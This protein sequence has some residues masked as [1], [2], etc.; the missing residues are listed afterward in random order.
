[1][2]KQIIYSL[3]IVLCIAVFF[4]YRSAGQ[5]RADTTAPVITV[6][7]EL[8]QPSVQD[9]NAALLA[10]VSAVDDRDGDVT[11]S[12]VVENVQLHDCDGTALVTYAAFDEAGNVA[13][14]QR[15]IRYIDYTCPR[16]SLTRAL[17]Y[18]ENSGFDVLS[19]IRAEDVS[20]GNISHLVKATSLDQ[21]SIGTPGEHQ[22]QFRVTN[23]LGDTA[24][25]V[26]PVEVY[27]QGTYDGT[28]ELSE[29]LVYFKAGDLLD[30][31]DY[32]LSFTL[33]GTTI[34]LDSRLPDGLKLEITDGVNMQKPGVY[35]VGYTVTYT[36]NNRTYTGYSVLIVVVEG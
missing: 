10:G 18:P 12:L 24:E 26:L 29:Y 2:K 3:L 34:P 23:S 20:D 31:R 25:L 19:D 22:I 17:V 13:K 28:L 30:V 11:A 16:F 5:M 1:M 14:A 15:K 21:Q 27:T 4:G 9:S 8:L 33:G 6:A 35:T 7:E 36:E 32:P